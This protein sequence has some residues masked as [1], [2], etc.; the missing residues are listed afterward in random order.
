MDLVLAPMIVN[1]LNI[2]ILG[3][4]EISKTS[5]TLAHISM[6]VA[7]RQVAC[8][9]IRNLSMVNVSLTSACPQGIKPSIVFL[10]L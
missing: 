9:I 3:D 7:G 2:V 6:N 5:E 8:S 4:A 10:T 1:H